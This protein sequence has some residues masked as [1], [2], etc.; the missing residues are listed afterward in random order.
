MEQEFNRPQKS[1]T[2]WRGEVHDPAALWKYV[3]GVARRKEDAHQGVRDENNDG[4]TP[5]DFKAR[6]NLHIKQ[7]RAQII[8]RRQGDERKAMGFDPE[9]LLLSEGDALLSLEEVLA[10]RL[11][12]GPAFQ[13]I[14]AFLR[15][16]GKLTGEFRRHMARHPELTFAATTRHLCR[17][18]RK[19]ADVTRDEVSACIAMSSISCA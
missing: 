12:S 17:A 18:I 4:M 7:M 16:I 3:T 11:Y 15:E 9:L 10:V 1:F 13:P 2:D 5:S 14:N 19:L 8:H 6:A